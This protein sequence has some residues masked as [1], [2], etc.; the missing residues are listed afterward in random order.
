LSNRLTR[1]EVKHHQ[2]SLAEQEHEIWEEDAWQVVT[3]YRNL[4]GTEDGRLFEI[5]TTRPTRRKM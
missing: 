2:L 1:F 3:C 4:G 5:I